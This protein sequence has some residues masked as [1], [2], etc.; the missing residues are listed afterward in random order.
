MEGPEGVPWGPQSHILF[1]G[2]PDRVAVIPSSV[3][4]LYR[5][6]VYTSPSGHILKG[7]C[8]GAHIS[9]PHTTEHEALLAVPHPE[10]WCPLIFFSFSDLCN[11]CY[12][13]TLRKAHFL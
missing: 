8:L 2:R 7:H 13:G 3:A 11:H 4:F 10:F 1:Q 6:I 9:L 12:C 5:Q